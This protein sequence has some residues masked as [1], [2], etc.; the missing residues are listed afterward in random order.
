M[1]SIYSDGVLFFSH[2]RSIAWRRSAIDADIAASAASRRSGC[3]R[4]QP[5]TRRIVIE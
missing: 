4:D 5:F 1:R 2:P 3:R